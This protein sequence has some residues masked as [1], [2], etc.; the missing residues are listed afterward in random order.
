M[1]KEDAWERYEYNPLTGDL[2]HRSGPAKGKKAGT[3]RKGYL[4]IKFKGKDYKAH[5]VVWLWVT[6]KFPCHTIDHINRIRSDNRFSN[7]RD[8]PQ[9]VN[10]RNKVKPPIGAWQTPC[11]NW[12]AQICINR[13]TIHIG[14]FRTEQ[15][16]K[17]ARQKYETE[18]LSQQE[19]RWQK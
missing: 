8:V 12:A 16:A 19:L 10:N 1:N 17:E 15:L 4:E 9:S 11:G 13:K 18:N 3:L 2:Y 7:L 6:G 14:T 5:R